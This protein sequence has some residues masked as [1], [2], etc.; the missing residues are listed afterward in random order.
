M[1]FIYIQFCIRVNEV[2][3]IAF[4]EFC[5]NLFQEMC[6]QSIGK[7]SEWKE[8]LKSDLRMTYELCDIWIMDAS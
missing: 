1:Q 3:V 7:G 4:S 8:S 2:Y 6:N 5:L